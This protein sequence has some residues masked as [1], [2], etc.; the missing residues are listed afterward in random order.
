MTAFQTAIRLV[1]GLILSDAGKNISK[2]VIRTG[3]AELV[4][5]IQRETRGR[6]SRITYS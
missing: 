4:R 3:T 5:Y 2:A 6:K 1:M